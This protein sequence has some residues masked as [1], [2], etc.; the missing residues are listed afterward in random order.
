MMN[1]KELYT[2]AWDN[3]ALYWKRGGID[4]FFVIETEVID[5]KEFWL[6]NHVHVRKQ[7]LVHK[8]VGSSE[9]EM[10]KVALNDLL[11]S[12]A[13]KIYESTVEL[14]RTKMIAQSNLDDPI[15]RFKYMYPV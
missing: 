12:G 14:H 15:S 8:V 4:A 11:T 6:I 3:W 9:E 1:Y 10:W 5:D 2:Q 13:A 7:L